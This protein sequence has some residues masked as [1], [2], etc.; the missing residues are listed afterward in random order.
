MSVIRS[1]VNLTSA[2]FPLI[3]KNQGQSII[4]GNQDLNYTP[5]LN[6]TQDG[7][8]P[9]NDR[10]I[11][12]IMY[13]ENV[14]PFNEGLQSVYY[15]PYSTDNAAYPVRKIFQVRD[16]NG[17]VG[18]FSMIVSGVNQ[19]QVLMYLDNG[20]GGIN[21]VLSSSGVIAGYIGGLITV[22][23]IN[24]QSYIYFEGATQPCRQYNFITNALDVVVL[25]N[26]A[27]NLV[28]APKGIFASNGYLCGW[29]ATRITWSS[30]ASVT[31][32]VPS[33]ATGAGATGVQ[34]ANSD[35]M[36]VRSN[37]RGAII[38]TRT[39]SVG[40][41]YTNNKNFPWNF[42][43]IPGAGGCETEPL[44]TR[45]EDDNEWH[46][47]Y[48]TYGLMKIGSTISRMFLPEVTE[49]LSGNQ[50]ES[51]DVTTNTFTYTP[52]GSGN[53]MFK[54]VAMVASRYLCI[55]YGLSQNVFMSYV[56]V[57]DVV[58]QRWGKLKIDHVEVFEWQEYNAFSTREFPRKSIGILTTLSG[59]SIVGFEQ[60]AL[61]ANG[62]VILGRYQY[63]RNRLIE[64]QKITTQ[65]V[66]NPGAA[67]SYRIRS[68]ISTDGQTIDRTVTGVLIS[69]NPNVLTT[70]TKVHG[71][72]NAVGLNHTIV[73]DGTFALNSMV[74]E[75][76]NHGRQ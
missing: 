13:C 71:F 57:I 5:G 36:V 54:K 15:T 70:Q 46:Y 18:Y 33:L 62:V 1:R 7:L 14:M 11:P 50:Y 52:L 16:L 6:P 68:G 10:G 49:F 28:T 35:I 58:T 34:E 17:N 66:S 37:V 41:T 65:N 24:G 72:D 44:M 73:I 55:S 42:R 12:Q 60:W 76:N 21:K 64:L 3:S 67:S 25:N 59:I 39:N 20:I 2:K 29:S 61:S 19:W 9:Q 38:Y 22:A 47:A 30:T 45:I 56:L 48:T 31:D 32:F 69:P 4:V 63:V 51:Y 40:M 26:F 75:F 8:I 27:A 23:Y 74:M 53:P 43:D